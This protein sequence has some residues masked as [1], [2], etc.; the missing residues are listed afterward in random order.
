MYGAFVLTFLTIL[1]LHIALSNLGS[2]ICPSCPIP[3]HAAL[4]AGLSYRSPASPRIRSC[5]FALQLSLTCFIEEFQG[6]V[7][8]WRLQA[9]YPVTLPVLRDKTNWTFFIIELSS[10]LKFFFETEGLRSYCRAL[11]LLL[12][13]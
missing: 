13:N 10:R 4:T 7:N 5:Y 11:L 2:A 1:L 9:S 6:A 3:E 12:Y 8:V